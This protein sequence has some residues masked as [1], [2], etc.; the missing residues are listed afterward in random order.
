MLPWG[1]T[2]TAFIGPQS[3]LKGE[4][5]GRVAR[6]VGFVEDGDGYKLYDHKSG[7]FFTSNSIR[8]FIISATSGVPVER[9][10]IVGAPENNYY[11]AISVLLIGGVWLYRSLTMLL[12]VSRR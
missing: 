2:V 8:P 4:N 11:S 6:F 5:K 9:T 1:T 3:R 7:T 10:K 12:P